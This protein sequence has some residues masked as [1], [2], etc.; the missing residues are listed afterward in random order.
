MAVCRARAALRLVTHTVGV[1]HCCACCVQTPLI[2]SR[3]TSPCPRPASY[4]RNTPLPAA[5]LTRWPTGRCSCIPSPRVYCA[6]DRLNMEL[7]PGNQIGARHR[8]HH[9]CGLPVEA[10]EM[11][12]GAGRERPPAASWHHIRLRLLHWRRLCI[13]AG[14][15]QG[16]GERASTSVFAPCAAAAAAAVFWNSACT[17]PEPGQELVGRRRRAGK[18]AH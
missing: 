12:R 5:R 9:P 13:E 17:H 10:T 4:P 6:V 3:R 16:T 8:Q 7:E 14:R 18:A 2:P 15:R 1:H 11:H